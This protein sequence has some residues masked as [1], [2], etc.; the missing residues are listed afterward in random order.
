MCI[1]GLIVCSQGRE[2]VVPSLFPSQS[3]KHVI[4]APAP[5]PLCPT[6]LLSPDRHQNQGPT[7]L[8]P[9]VAKYLSGLVLTIG[10]SIRGNV[11]SDE[12]NIVS[13]RQ[14]AQISHDKLCMIL[15]TW[16]GVCDL[17]WVP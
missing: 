13:E 5:Q 7:D 14:S 15:V 3:G 17:R 16:A 12:S 6:S 11:W 2:A 8:I 4:S 1:A 10:N 9:G